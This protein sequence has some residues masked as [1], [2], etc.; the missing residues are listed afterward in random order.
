MNLAVSMKSKVC[1]SDWRFWASTPF[2]L[3]RAN[4]LVKTLIQESTLYTSIILR[5]S[6]VSKQKLGLF[7]FQFRRKFP[8]VKNA[9]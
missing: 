2:L 4:K 7:H 5:G 9:L 1:F 3:N 6:E 8:D